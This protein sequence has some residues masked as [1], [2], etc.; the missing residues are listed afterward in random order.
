MTQNGSLQELRDFTV[1]IRNAETNTI[2]GTGIAVSV[3]GKVVT[4]RHVIEAAGID[5]R[6]ANGAEVGVYFSKARDSSKKNC[7]ATIAQCF[8]DHDDDVVLLQ[9]TEGSSPLDP[10][11]IAVIGTADKSARHAFRSYGYRALGN[12]PGGWA[13]GTIMGS[14]DGPPDLN[15]HVEPVQLDSKQIAPGMSGSGVFDMERNLLVGIIS[16]T[17]YPPSDDPKD[18]DTAWSVNARVLSFAPLGLMIQDESLPLRP[19]LQPQPTF[20]ISR[21]RPKEKQMLVNAPQLLDEWVGRIHLLESITSNWANSNKRITGLIGFGGEGKS[22]LARQWLENL[23]KDQSKLQPDGIFWWGFYENR[24]VDDFFEAAL[25]Y[26]TGDAIAPQQIPSASAKAHQI[27]AMLANGR[28]LFVLDGVEVLQYQDGD[29]YGSFQS[30]DLNSFLSYFAT[31]EHQSFCLITS[32]APLADL[33]KFKTYAQHDV[34]RLSDKDGRMLLENLDV[35][36]KPEQLDKIV[37]DWNGHA[38]TLSL[39]GSYLVKVHDGD[40][41]H[42]GD[43]DIEEDEEVES[44]SPDQYKHVG[45]ILRRYDEHL[46]KE[47]KAFLILFSAFRTPVHVSALD[48]VFRTKTDAT[49]LNVSLTNLSSEEFNALVKRLVNYRILRFDEKSQTYTTH[50]LIRNHYFALFTKGDPSQEKATHEQIK[51]YYLSIAGDTPKFPTLDDL[52]PL[53]E[54]VHHAC[55]AGAYDEAYKIFQ[56]HIRQ[57]KRKV[58]IHQLG[59][60]ET[61]LALDTEFFRN[62]DLSQEPAVSDKN[63]RRFLLNAVGLCL[64]SLGHLREAVPYFERKNKIAL[65]MQDWKNLS[66]GYQNLAELHAHLGALEASAEA[67][68]QALDLARKAGDKDGEVKTLSY[69][70]RNFSL[71]GE[72]ENANTAFEKAWV[73]EKED[74]PSVSC[75]SRNPGLWY[76]EHLLLIK[77]IKESRLLA[78]SNLE[79]CGKY[80]WDFLVSNCHLVLGDLDSDAGNHVSARAHYESALKIARSIQDRGVL[81]EALLARG[82]FFAKHLKDANAASSDLNEALSYCVESGY[83]IYEADVRVALAWANLAVSD[84]QSAKAEAERALQMSNEM[85]YHWG[86]VDAEE[87][88][89]NV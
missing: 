14:V 35:K 85:G 26:I 19:V 37:A 67:A 46:T 51:E 89:K 54:V 62:G 31:S 48:K 81:I 64:M 9:L 34:D 72:I 13:E 53:I 79:Y 2:L 66:N 32:R 60:Y 69:Q 45:R 12:Y 7:R 24:S 30:N 83:R 1:Q 73:L 82:R 22:S 71:K 25:K 23:L 59:A 47:E 21:L 52:K 41:N 87:V 36:G 28:Y 5:P 50:P 61:E 11:Q 75:L 33:M 44:S 55:Q 4:C 15:L 88:L 39:I 20:D 17:Y 43:F 56:D 65:E 74:D 68:R 18:R 84:Q 78:V 63:H 29:Q 8:E 3:D 58:T 76:A 38:L 10:E 57:G 86:R 40:A 80:H 27:A 70:G 16:E 42:V 6:N 49:A 77:Q